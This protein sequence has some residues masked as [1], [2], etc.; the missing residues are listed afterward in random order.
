MPPK[1]A[2]RFIASRMV[3]FEL[4]TRVRQQDLGAREACHVA[5]AMSAKSNASIPINGGRA[6]HQRSHP[7]RKARA[8]S[9]SFWA[10][11]A[12]LFSPPTTTPSSPQHLSQIHGS[13]RHQIQFQRQL[14][15]Q[16]NQILTLRQI[17]RRH[18]YQGIRL[19]IME[20]RNHWK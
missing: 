19:R 11:S 9:S 18:L 5:D 1:I 20:I 13:R 12:S 2:A 16:Y 7:K 6:C 10:I 4:A 14:R 8:Q 3:L 15:I 17:F